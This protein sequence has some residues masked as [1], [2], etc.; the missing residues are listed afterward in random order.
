MKLNAY[1]IITDIQIGQKST[2]NGYC[3]VLYC[4]KK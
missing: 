3:I 2:I 1:E 4:Y